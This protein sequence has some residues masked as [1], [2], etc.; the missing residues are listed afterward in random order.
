MFKVLTFL[1]VAVLPLQAVQKV[2]ALKEEIVLS[3][4]EGEEI[5]A[6]ENVIA[7][8]EKRLQDEKKLKL[9]MEEFKAQQD[10]FFLGEQTSALAAQMCRTARHILNIITECHL[11]YLFSKRYMEELTL[12]SSIAGKNTPSRP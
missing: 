9:L 12:F 10:R 6:I 2:P 4:D 5:Q 3:A 11:Q 1:L 8:T 7:H